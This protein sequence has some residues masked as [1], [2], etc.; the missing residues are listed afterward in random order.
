[1]SATHDNYSEKTLPIESAGG[2]RK[3]SLPT[4]PVLP[5]HRP[6]HTFTSST[7]S[8]ELDAGTSPLRPSVSRQSRQSR[9]GEVY[10]RDVVVE[11]AGLNAVDLAATGRAVTRDRGADAGNGDIEGGRGKAKAGDPV[12][13]AEGNEEVD[14]D[15]GEED[16]VPRMSKVRIIWLAVTMLL[17]FFMSVRRLRYIHCQ[18]KALY[19]C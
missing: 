12:E 6:P 4:L 1:M 9:L 15:G 8:A 14:S 10:G 7:D 3:S 18:M 2:S 16:E 17:T 5:Q 19:H 13:K 11:A